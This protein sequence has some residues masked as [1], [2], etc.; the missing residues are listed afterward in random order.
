MIDVLILNYNDSDSTINLAKR[1]SNYEIVRNILVVDNCSPVDSY[2]LLKKTHINKMRVV[3]TA[4]NKGYGFGNNFGIDYLTKTCKSDYILIANPDIEID[5]STIRNLENFL[6]NNSEYAVVA[7]MMCNARK[8]KNYGCAFKT[9]NCLKYILSFG[10]VLNKFFK[11][12]RYN[13]SKQKDKIFLDVDAVAGSCLMVCADKMLKYGMYDEKIFLYCEERV[14]SL[15]LKRA[16]Q[17]T[18]LLLNE[19]FIHK[20]ST[21]IG[22]TFDPMKANKIMSKSRRY[23]I[24]NYYNANKVKLVLTEIMLIINKIEL[25]LL[26]K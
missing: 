23:V 20:H 26:N 9:D 22:K 1:L 4:S 17:K 8:E 16:K 24:K 13:L 7:P 12:E 10:L 21:S 25:L 19:V 18:A 14:L 11:F 15:K 3:Q 2:N 6:E 5:E